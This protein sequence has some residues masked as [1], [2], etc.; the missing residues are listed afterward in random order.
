MNLT[1]RD[2]PI[3]LIE[4]HDTC[5]TVDADIKWIMEGEVETV[6]TKDIDGDIVCD[7]IKRAMA[8]LDTLS[9]I[10]LEGS[11]KTKI[12]RKRHTQSST[13]TSVAITLWSMRE[14]C[15]ALW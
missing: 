9:V 5:N 7:R 15:Y 6:V 1:F 8:F 14:G 4:T 3:S 11:I 2:L 13:S 10:L 12:F